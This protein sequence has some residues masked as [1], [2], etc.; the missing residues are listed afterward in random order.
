MSVHTSRAHGGNLTFSRPLPLSYGHIYLSDA[1]FR[2]EELLERPCLWCFYHSHSTNDRAD[3]WSECRKTEFGKNQGHSIVCSEQFCLLCRFKVVLK[4]LW[5]STFIH[6]N[7]LLWGRRNE[8]MRC[9]FIKP[10]GDKSN[11]VFNIWSNYSLCGDYLEGGLSHSTVTGSWTCAGQETSFFSCA[12]FDKIPPAQSILLDRGTK[13]GYRFSRPSY[14][15]SFIK[16]FLKT[17]TSGEQFPLDFT[18]KNSIFRQWCVS[19]NE[20]EGVH[21]VRTCAVCSGSRAAGAIYF[22]T[23]CIIRLRRTKTSVLQALFV[24]IG[25]IPASR[26]PEKQ[27]L[28]HGG[29][30]PR[31]GTS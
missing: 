30:G 16:F 15:F 13:G 27:W 28:F 4:W 29:K 10:L 14:T 31:G 25:M 3:E 2:E 8:A 5:E 21:Y 24:W 6:S 18:I 12:I 1:S 26:T 22:A 23:P 11:F 7:M 20:A 9:C 19:L 17:N